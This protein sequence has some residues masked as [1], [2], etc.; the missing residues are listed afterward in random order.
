MG[1]TK[2]ESAKI[3]QWIGF[4]SVELDLNIRG[5]SLRRMGY[6][7]SHDK[8]VE[9]YYVTNLKIA[10]KALNTYLASHE[11]LVGNSVTLADIITTCNLLY[12]FK[13]LMPKVF[14]S[15]F[16]HVEKYFWAM[17]DQPNFK[18]V[19]GEVKQA[20][21]VIPLSLAM[22]PERP[23]EAKPKAVSKNEEVPKPVTT[24]KEEAKPENPIDAPT[25]MV[26][27]D[28]K[29]LYSDIKTKSSLS[30][31][32]IKGFWDMFAAESYSLW[33]CDYKHND[34]NE[35]PVATMD[36]VKD[37]LR[38]LK[39]IRAYTFGK[40]L[41]TGTQVSDL[42]IDYC[43]ES[44]EMTKV[45]LSVDDQK[46]RVIQMIKSEDPFEDEEIVHDFCFM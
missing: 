17:I 18:K 6:F 14:T 7:N 24:E 21:A 31:A 37:F 34:K 29:K 9:V 22:K 5:W 44:Y 16:P 11:F 12:G 46:K 20:A 36:M 35:R 41:I 3:E 39:L 32:A 10:L 1:R 13:W 33:F 19:T 23:K 26:L 15:K 45:G 28:W 8:L 38:S 43:K 25:K 4:S 42:L 40:I 27:D 2:I 30:E